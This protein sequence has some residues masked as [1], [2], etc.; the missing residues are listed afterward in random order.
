VVSGRSAPPQPSGACER[1]ADVL[2]DRFVEAFAIAG[3]AEDALA[4]ARRTVRPL[5][6]TLVGPR[7]EANMEYLARAA[8]S[9]ATMAGIE[10]NDRI[11]TLRRTNC[12]RDLPKIPQES[13]WSRRS[14]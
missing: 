8:G 6:L 12:I 4:Q 2:D 9:S 14:P 5:V 10:A 1:P 11:F 3:T 7:P 13:G